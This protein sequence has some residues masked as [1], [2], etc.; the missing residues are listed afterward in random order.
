VLAKSGAKI[1]IFGGTVSTTGT[2]ANGVF[3][4]GTGSSIT[5]SNAAIKATS[6]GGHGAMAS[7]GGSV[8]LK[9]VDIDTAGANSAPLATDRGGGTI[10]ASG[11]TIVSSGTDSPGI[12]STGA[13]SVSGAQIKATGAEAV[14]IEG[15]NSVALKDTSLAAAKKSG[16]MIYQSMSGDAQGAKGTFTMTGGSLAAAAGPLFYVT[17][18][19]GVVS[20]KGVTLGEASGTLIQAAA[21]NWGTKGSNGGVARFTADAETLRATWSR[22]RSARSR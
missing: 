22:T 1:T 21:G 3:A 10:T 20:V 2:G 9:N 8:T 18:S 12:Y 15:S 4:Y 19:T 14:V 16:V 6:Q 7:G 17:N 13:I 11:G 5:M